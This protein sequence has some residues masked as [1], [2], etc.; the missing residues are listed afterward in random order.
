[1]S[2]IAKSITINHDTKNQHFYITDNYQFIHITDEGIQNE[3]CIFDDTILNNARH[4]AD[5]MIGEPV[6]G[7]KEYKD[8]I[9]K[10][11]VTYWSCLFHKHI[12]EYL[13]INNNVT[14]VFQK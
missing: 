1:M 11:R 8:Y 6:K 9:H 12:W 14:P 3:I 5:T 10:A 4:Y 7:I 2:K 13:N